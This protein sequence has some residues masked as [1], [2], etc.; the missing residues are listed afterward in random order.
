MALMFLLSLSLSP[1]S[2]KGKLW[3]YFLS[4]L[5]NPRE[6]PGRNSGSALETYFITVVDWN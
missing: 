6:I 1:P 3:E 5:S 4:A 2:L